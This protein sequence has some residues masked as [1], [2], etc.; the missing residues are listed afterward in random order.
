M[1]DHEYDRIKKILPDIE[2]KTSPTFCLAK[3]H[4]VTIYL[5]L[6]ETHSCYHPQPHGIPLDELKENPS[7]LHNTKQKKLERKMMLEGKKPEGCNY[8]WNVESMGPDYISDRKQRTVAIHEG[9]KSRLDDIINNPWD[10]NVNPEYIELSFG[11]TCNFKCG[12]CHPRYS[13]RFLDEI[14]EHGQYQEMFSGKYDIEWF[15]DKLQTD[16]ETNPYVKAWWQWWPEVSKTLS[17]LRITGGEPTIHGSTYRLLD[18]INKNPMP[19]LELN[20]NSNLGA[21]PKLFDRFIDKLKPIIEE[22]KVKDFKLFTSIDTWDKDKAEYMRHGLDVELFERNFNKYLE[23]I[24]DSRLSLMITFN[25]LCVSNFDSLLEKILEWR[26]KYNNLDWINEN[27]HPV[28][29]I[30][31][32]T[33]YLKEPPH[34]DMNILP[35]KDF[36]HYMDTHLKFMEDNLEKW[37]VNKFDHLEVAKFRR[38][39]NYFTTN[40]PAISYLRKGQSDFYSF[41]TQHDKRRDTE[42][43]NAFPEYTDFYNHCKKI[44]NRYQARDRLREKRRLRNKR[45]G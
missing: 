10:M 4:H 31:I 33:P 38:V 24:P 16:E 12:Y 1:I 45:Y 17:I 34:Y 28:Q 30:Q 18:E 29:R 3:W 27:G 43:L 35:K 42:F 5:H 11:N 23:E 44:N 6:G 2:K 20:I 39:H 40:T 22:K 19:N 14:K 36:G 21:N 9:D 7:A 26:G 32:D 25:N 41:F 37:N 15:I 13:S 8:C